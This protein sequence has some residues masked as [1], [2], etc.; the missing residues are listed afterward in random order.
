MTAKIAV[1]VDA[2]TTMARLSIRILTTAYS[3]KIIHENHTYTDSP[4]HSFGLVDLTNE[5]DHLSRQI[6]IIV[7]KFIGKEELKKCFDAEKEILKK[8]LGIGE[9]DDA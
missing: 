9:D 1:D 2:L 4:D 7:G 3:Q 5:I 6:C 8:E